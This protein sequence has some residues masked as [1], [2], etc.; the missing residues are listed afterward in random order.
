MDGMISV[1]VPVYN[2]QEYIEECVE[3]LFAQTYKNLEIILIDDGST[4][5]SLEICKKFA[6]NDSRIKLLES[7]HSGVSAARNAGLDAACGE[8]VFFLD[9]DDIIHP[10]LLE[11]LINGISGT[12]ATMAGTDALN[13]VQRNWEQAKERIAADNTIPE[14]KYHNHEESLYAIFHG[15]S[16]LNLIGGIMMRRD[17][18]GETR[19][20]TDLF[21]GEDYYFV[22]ENLIKNSSTVFLKQKWYYARIHPNNSSKQF[23]FDAFWTRFYR[24]KLVWESEASF[25]RQEYV[26]I[27]KN[28]ALGC[29]LRC[30][31][32]NDPKSEDVKKMCSALKEHKQDFL[33]GSSLKR[34]LIFLL[35]A[36]MPSVFLKFYKLKKK[37]GK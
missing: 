33:S 34:K 29:F 31:L 14:C 10:S 2:R 26:N 32:N 17:L 22:Y 11:A 9:S 36:Y 18:I 20:K 30:L 37:I 7:N 25:G 8:Y 23:G 27:Q 4:D 21:I 15:N 19:F 3:S 16:P 35:Y 24:R 1:I 28:D 13:I 12:D 5:K 6:K